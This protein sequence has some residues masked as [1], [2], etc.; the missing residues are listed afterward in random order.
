M[1]SHP[2]NW[3]FSLATLGWAISQHAMPGEIYTWKDENGNLHYGD[4]AAIKNIDASVKRIQVAKS[5]TTKPSY[6]LLWLCCINPI[7]PEI[8]RVS[9]AFNR[10]P[11]GNYRAFPVGS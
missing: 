7:L 6:T 9:L 4:K 8:P 5:A 2:A 3:S 11:P 10:R 1:N